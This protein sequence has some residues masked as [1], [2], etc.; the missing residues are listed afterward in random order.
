MPAMRPFLLPLLLLAAGCGREPE[1]PPPS[2]P[3]QPPKPS[4]QGRTLPAP[5]VRIAFVREDGLWT[6]NEDG[7]DLQRIVP[8]TCPRAS[9]PAWAPDRRWIAFTAE[10]DPASNLYARN[11]FIAR[12]DGADLLQLTPG[13]RAGPPPEDAPKGIVRGRAVLATDISRRPLAG[14]SV[15]ASAMRRPE[16]TDREGNFQTY[17]PVG[18]GWVKLSGLVDGR[19]VLAWRFA[20]PAEGRLTDLKDV[21][22]MFADDDAVA[23]P[24]WSS[25][26]KQVLYVLRHSPAETRTGAPRATLRRIRTDGSGDETVATFTESTI[27][28]GPA[29]RGDSAWCKLADGTIL[30]FDLKNKAVADSR[31]A[32]ICAPDALAVSPDGATVATLSME[33]TG[34]R[35]IVL[36]RREG[37]EIAATFP[38]QE[39]VPH[40]IDFSP[41]GRRLVMDRHAPDGKPSIWILTLATKQLQKLIEQGSSPVWNGR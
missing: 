30:R 32:A 8:P 27:I 40:A 10:L 9:E 36:I 12:P 38:P 41:D 18:G 17:L 37:A 23:S 22:V 24:A 34:A 13:P 1:P 2:G 6:V 20:S 3:I 25:D 33:A 14:L 16:I 21:P 28:A 31:P 26:G 29:V 11:L 5:Q 7:G 35:S 4:G 19:R 39:P 15:S